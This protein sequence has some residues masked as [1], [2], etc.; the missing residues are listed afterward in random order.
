MKKHIGSIVFLL[1]LVLA[2][3]CA[4]DVGPFDPDAP[5][6]APVFTMSAVIGGDSVSMAAGPD[7][8]RMET[9]K[10]PTDSAPGHFLMTGNLNDPQCPNCGPSMELKLWHR[11]QTFLGALPD[12]AFAPGA[13]SLGVAE[14]PSNTRT[15]Q[16]DFLPEPALGTPQQVV[17]DF[18]DGQTGQ[19]MQVTH[20]YQTG[21]GVPPQVLVS[22]TAIY[23]PL[24][25]AASVNVIDLSVPFYFDIDVVTNGQ[26]VM[27][28]ITPALTP[29]EGLAFIDMGDGSLPYSDFSFTHQ[30]PGPGQYFMSVAIFAGTDSLFLLQYQRVI[31]IGLP[32]C[33]G[34]FVYSEI[35]APQ[36][37][38][39]REAEIIYNDGNGNRYSSKPN[40]SGSEQFINFIHHSA[41]KP[42]EHG[43][44][45]YQ[46]EIEAPCWLYEVNGLDS[47]E[48][49]SAVLNWGLPY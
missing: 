24:C 23:G 31:N 32:N 41:Y 25:T 29:N 12:S 40:I 47:I 48:I 15:L 8:Y 33:I 49:S 28:D 6:Q 43:D 17:W 1:A 45:V 2:A 22:C 5:E 35:L 11:P 16:F 34:N 39:E 18:G 30:Y 36:P 3:G 19:G 13:V 10:A 27:V 42:N 44:M 46:V 20:T 14:E 26:S 4:K 9:T 38:L 7:G 37:V 21:L